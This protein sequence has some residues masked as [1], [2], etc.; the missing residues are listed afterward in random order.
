MKGE[1][2]ALFDMDGTIVDFDSQMRHDI[3]LLKSPEEPLIDPWD[4]SKPY[5]RERRRTIMKQNG[6][7]KNLPPLQSGI[8]LLYEAAN[9]G[10]QIHILTK[11]PSS[12]P[13]AWKE[14]VEWCDE[15][16]P[17]EK[18]NIKIT[19]TADKG[20]VYG[21]FLVDDFPEYIE[22]WLQ[23]RPRGLVIMPAHDHNENFKHP[24]VIRYEGHK[25]LRVI[26]PNLLRVLE[27]EPGEELKIF[28][29]G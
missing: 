25:D 4:R 3:N 14:K 5:M 16:L 24:N 23:W 17:M 26:L 19:M 29:Q 13:D 9:L 18:L 27:R 20:L 2:I 1:N 11:A 7:W 28:N 22:R 12:K 8:D 10:F 21:K 6:W 15:Y